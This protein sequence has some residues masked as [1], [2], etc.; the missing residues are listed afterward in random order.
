MK[1]HAAVNSNFNLNHDITDIAYLHI[2]SIS[3][4][5]DFNLPGLFLLINCTEF[6]RFILLV[7]NNARA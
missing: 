1:N 4:S 7:D 5:Y 3:E 6:Y 2:I